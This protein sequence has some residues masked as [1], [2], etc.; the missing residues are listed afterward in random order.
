MHSIS[1]PNTHDLFEVVF[2][3]TPDVRVK[4]KFLAQL[5]G[6]S[7]TRCRLVRKNKYT[8]NLTKAL[9]LRRSEQMEN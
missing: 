3:G 2:H 6:L 9:T 1:L 4:I 8:S 7:P 5:V